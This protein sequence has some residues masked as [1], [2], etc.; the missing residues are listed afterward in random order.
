MSFAELFAQSRAEAARRGHPAEE[1]GAAAVL[2]A[3]ILTGIGAGV[4]E[5]RVSPV[6]F[7][8]TIPDKPCT[9]AWARLQ[10]GQGYKA[11]NLR[12]EIITLDEIH[13]QTLR[14]LDG[15]R[16]QSDLTALLVQAVQ[17]GEFVLRPENEKAVVTDEAQM[18]QLLDSALGKVLE[19]LA[20]QAF[21][22][23]RPS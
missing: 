15:T 10:T 20:R 21:I 7:T 2:R 18:P 19:N 23:A 5:W 6:A 3:D 4:I 13:R 12:G 8:T 11:T 22:A 16:R 9:S 17:A 1:S 14:H